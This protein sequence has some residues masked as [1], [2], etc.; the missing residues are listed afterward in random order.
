MRVLAGLLI[1]TV[2]VAAA[3]PASAQSSSSTTTT[4][5]GSNTTTTTTSVDAEGRNVNSE[6]TNTT[7]GAKVSTRF[8]GTTY[9]PNGKLRRVIT[10]TQT[11]NEGNGYTYNY[12]VEDF[13]ETGQLTERDDENGTVDAGGTRTS[14]T[15]KFTTFEGKTK[16]VA[17]QT[18]DGKR[19]GD[20]TVTTIT[21]TQLH[22][23]TIAIAA[24]AIAAIVVPHQGGCFS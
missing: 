21:A 6:T 10:N 19:W 24:A 13:D 3:L 22:F 17:T 7:T 1:L 12:T 4:T 9:Y 11:Y 20:A 16:K 23:W 14:G 15:R 18:W 2:F 5:S 8:T